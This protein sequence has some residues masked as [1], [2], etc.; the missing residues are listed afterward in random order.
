MNTRERKV[1]IWLG[2]AI[3][4]IVVLHMILRIL[5]QMD[6]KS[7]KDLE[8]YML[9]A[10]ENI[11]LV[12]EDRLAIK[13]PTE[14]HLEKNKN[15]EDMINV[16]NYT[17]ILERLN[18]IFPEEIKE[19]KVARHTEPELVA[20]T[21]STVPEIT[22]D[23]KRYILTTGVDKLFED[24]YNEKIEKIVNREIVVD[25]LNANGIPG[26]ARK[27]G[28]ALKNKMQAK[29]NAAN[30]EEN[31][32]ESYIII[33]ELDKR[34]AEKL[35]MG[36]N[37]KYLKIK[38]DTTIPT[39]ANV[40]IILG[41]EKTKV[42]DI[43]VVGSG[44]LTSGYVKV[45]KDSGY[46]GVNREVSST[47]GKEIEIRHNKEDYFVAYKIGQKLGINKF[48]EDNSLKNKITIITG[49]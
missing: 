28:E 36:I 47:K 8:R 6:N 40:V 11:Y 23:N 31:I 48:L 10:K 14:I 27:T 44:D 7:M 26:H 33:N 46:I 22:I 49:E 39:L 35:V 37:E 1:Y 29:Y 32:N 30:Y 18:I 24:I 4:S 13:I 42:Y 19:Y 5:I 41:R 2:L 3:A 25:I 16:K 38:E 21:I 45:L 9:V 34:E 43:N 12:Y 15:I 17:D 20:R